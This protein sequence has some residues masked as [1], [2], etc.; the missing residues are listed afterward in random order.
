MGAP[1]RWAGSG[2]GGGASWG[3]TTLLQEVVLSFP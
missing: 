3:S 1:W 2:T